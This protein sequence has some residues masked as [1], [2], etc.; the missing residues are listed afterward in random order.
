MDFTQHDF[1]SLI[2]GNRKMGPTSPHEI[3][4]GKV[5][6]SDNKNT[7]ILY[8]SS[9]LHTDRAFKDRLVQ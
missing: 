4:M 1:V 8:I 6:K 5:P 9:V 3:N 7:I 2:E